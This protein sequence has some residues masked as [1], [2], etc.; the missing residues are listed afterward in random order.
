MKQDQQDETR[1]DSTRQEKPR[2]LKPKSDFESVVNSKEDKT[3]KDKVSSPVVTTAY[4]TL[5]GLQGTSDPRTFSSHAISSRDVLTR[6]Y[7]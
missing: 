6:A 4:D 7:A 5:T 1:Q 3:R 2:E